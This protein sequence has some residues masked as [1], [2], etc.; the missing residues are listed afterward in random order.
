MTIFFTYLSD[1][2][3]DLIYICL[4]YI[5]SEAECVL[6]SM[7]MLGINKCLNMIENL[8]SNRYILQVKK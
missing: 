4:R 2:A 3:K 5:L 6:Y 7:H 8:V 1:N